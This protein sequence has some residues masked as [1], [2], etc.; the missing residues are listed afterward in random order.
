MATKAKVKIIQIFPNLWINVSKWQVMIAEILVR[1]VSIKGW[2]ALTGQDTVY[3][4]Q[5]TV[6]ACWSLGLNFEGGMK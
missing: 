3:G 2:N 5:V 4:N 6:I 1:E